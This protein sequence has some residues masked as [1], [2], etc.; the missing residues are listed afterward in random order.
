MNNNF[1]VAR[2]VMGGVAAFILLILVIS[3]F[4][5]VVV[6]AGERGVVFNNQSGIENR[7][8]G[9]GTHFRTPLLEQVIDMPIRTQATNFDETAGTQD[10]LLVF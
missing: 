6:P 10:W 4:P 8:L 2:Y 1:P 5:I 9:E 3:F 7:I